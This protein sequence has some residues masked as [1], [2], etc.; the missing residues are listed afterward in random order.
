MPRC[1]SACNSGDSDNENT[2]YTT[3]L[4]EHDENNDG[5]FGRSGSHLSL[6]AEER[7]CHTVAAS[8]KRGSLVYLSSIYAR[9]STLLFNLNVNVP[10]L[11][12]V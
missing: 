9:P 1:T 2:R 4:M 5:C 8:S 3:A 6:L 12:A 10:T 7:D 11:F